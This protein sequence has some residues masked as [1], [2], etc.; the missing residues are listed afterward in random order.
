MAVQP[1]SIQLTTLVGFV[2]V[3]VI[4]VVASAS[5]VA[6]SFIVDYNMIIKSTQDV[7]EYT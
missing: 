7:K 2:V 3:V 5:E 6:H 4:I 1:C